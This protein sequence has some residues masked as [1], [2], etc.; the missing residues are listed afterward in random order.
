MD[1]GAKR[2]G[3]KLHPALT[4]QSVVW[5]GIY[6][7]GGYVLL[8]HSRDRFFTRRPHHALDFL[9]VTEKDQRRNSLDPVALC[10]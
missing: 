9:S 1:L 3:A 4:A 7:L 8:D 5:L 10:G 6:G 2:P